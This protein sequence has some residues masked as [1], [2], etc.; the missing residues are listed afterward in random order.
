MKISSRAGRIEPFYVMEVAKA[1]SA[2][3]RELAHTDAPMIF[4]NIG[5]PDFTAPPPVL[6]AAEACLR[7]GQTQ[8]TQATGLDGLRQGLS[9]WYGQRF[10]LDIAPE[11]IVITAGAW[12]GP[13]LHNLGVPLEVRRK[14]L[15]WY[16]PSDAATATASLTSSANGFPCFLFELPS[17]I[18]YGFPTVDERGQWFAQE[19][20]ARTTALALITAAMHDACAA[21]AYGPAGAIAILRPA[22][23][24]FEADAAALGAPDLPVEVDLAQDL[25]RLMELRAPQGT[26]YGQ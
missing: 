16:E 20:T 13:L 17:G 9:R 21:Y 22:L 23:A 5:E 10:G 2:M 14:P 1:A 8:Y 15:M 24:R 7:A 26:L 4:L 19:A 11:R 6:A 25:L 18:F 3:A 12:S